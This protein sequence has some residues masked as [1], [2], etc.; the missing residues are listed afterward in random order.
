[1]KEKLEKSEDEAR[2]FGIS[3]KKPDG[4]TFITA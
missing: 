2:K 1:M 4:G 3:E